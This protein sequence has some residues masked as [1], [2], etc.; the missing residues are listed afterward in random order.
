MRLGLL[1]YAKQVYSWEFMSNEWSM[2]WFVHLFDFGGKLVNPMFSSS[3]LYH[4]SLLFMVRICL[5]NTGLNSIIILCYILNVQTYT[6]KK[7]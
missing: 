4:E 6:E 2:V 1:L 7:I 5:C 3:L